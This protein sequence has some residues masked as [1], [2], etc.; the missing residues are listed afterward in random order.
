[1][2][3]KNKKY[4][5]VVIGGGVIGCSVAYHLCRRGMKVAL[6]ERGDLASGTSSHCD[7]YAMISDK[8][9]GKDT[10]QG[11]KS[12]AYLQ[13]IASTFSYDVEVSVR[14]SLWITESEE[15]FA[16]ASDYVRKQQ[17]AGYD[18]TILNQK[19]L[20][21]RE[22]Y[23]NPSLPGGFWCAPD[24]SVNPYKFCFGF[25]VEAKKL[26]L[27]VFL[28]E[29]VRSILRDAKGA[30]TGIVTDKQTI[31]T[32]TVVNCC[33]VWAPFI[34]KMVDLDIPVIPRK[35]VVVLSEATFPIVKQKVQEYGYMAS[36]F[37]DLS[38]ERKLD[39]EVERNNVSCVV[40][41][42]ESNNLMIGSSRNFH[43]ISQTSEI[44]LIRAIMRRAVY[45]L[46]IL[47][48]INCLR[49]YAGVRPYV[50]D[51]F[52]IVSGVEEVPGF[53]IAAGHEGDGISLAA[54]TGKIFTQMFF[55]EEADMD[56]HFLRFSRFKEQVAHAPASISS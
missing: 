21:E 23:L 53:Y 9:P 25:V 4:D 2:S 43:G 15:E 38:Y 26:G 3:L 40:E 55:G 12:I 42:T 37:G 11:A 46:P 13:E 36:K 14:G 27:D 16:L 33:G 50:D 22:P 7:T 44:E 28:Y 19:E 30:V 49:T 51:H 35:G 47:K 1:M 20:L 5:A 31:D 24:M 10:E 32:P 17:A 39:P 8:Q 52:P 48:E 54:I 56:M 29:E 34:G 18:L 45:F 41:Q 6:V